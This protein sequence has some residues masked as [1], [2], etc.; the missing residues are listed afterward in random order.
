MVS[1][2]QMGKWC[3]IAVRFD[4]THRIPSLTFAP[5]INFLALI[6]RIATLAQMGQ[7]ST[8]SWRRVRAPL[9]RRELRLDCRL[10]RS[11][12]RS[13]PPVLR[14]FIVIY[15]SRAGGGRVM[16]RDAMQDAGIIAADNLNPQKARVLA[17]LGLTQADTTPVALQRLFEI[18]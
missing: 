15:S 11:A 8:P 5:S 17:M 10:R 7:R 14:A 3:S 2:T 4:A 9:F 1:P 12:R 16:L 13:T 6:L 18:Y